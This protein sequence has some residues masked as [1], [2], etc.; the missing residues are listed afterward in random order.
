MY[1]LSQQAE[2]AGRD[3]AIFIFIFSI[4]DDVVI[5]FLMHN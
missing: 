2:L 1:K 4:Q 3:L 5:G